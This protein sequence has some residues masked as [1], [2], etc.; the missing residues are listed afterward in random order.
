MSVET[1]V[2]VLD[3][4]SEHVAR[5]KNN[6]N[7]FQVRNY[8]VYMTNALN[9]SNRRFHCTFF[10][11]LWTPSELQVCNKR[12]KQPK[13]TLQASFVEYSKRRARNADLHV[14]KRRDTDN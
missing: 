14:K 6:R 4:N 10:S 12:I 7:K 5:V 3:G 1:M 11:A 2:L 9:R 8:V 13:M